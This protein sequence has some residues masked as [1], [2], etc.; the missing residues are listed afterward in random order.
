MGAGYAAMAKCR[1]AAVGSPVIPPGISF[2]PKAKAAVRKVERTPQ[3]H[4]DREAGTYNTATKFFA[5]LL[6]SDIS[7]RYS[8][9]RVIP[10][11]QGFHPTAFIIAGDP[12][13]WSFE[14]EMLYAAARH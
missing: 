1:P 13:P 11:P 3:D 9:I 14:G 2:T 12:V 4:A 6:G 10:N 7:G 5:L 8:F